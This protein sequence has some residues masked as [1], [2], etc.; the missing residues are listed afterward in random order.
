MNAHTFAILAF[1][2]VI[3]ST[4]SAGADDANAKPLRLGVAGLTH[5]HVHAVLN[6]AHDPDVELVGIAEANGELAD[7]F[8]KQHA[9]DRSLVYP[10]LNELLD[11]TQP[12]AV[13]AFGSIYEHLA[14]VEACAPR[15]IHVMVEKPLAVS[16]KHAERMA[17]LARKHGVL[18]LTNYET[19]WYGS[20]HELYDRVLN[21]GQVGTLRKL[22]VH[23]GHRGP[24]E[25]GCNA[26]FLE[27]LTDPVQNGGGAITDF[28]CYGANL[29][30][31]LMQN[32]RPRSVTAVTQQLKPDKYPHVDDEATILLTYPSAQ[33]V[34]QAS[35]NWP[36]SRKDL[37]AYG[38]DGYVKTIDGSEM[39]IRLSEQATEEA[40]TA[41]P[42][43][44]P[45]HDP[46]AYFRAAVRGELDASTG[47]SSL[48]NNLIVVEILDAARRSA[49]EG[50]VVEIGAAG[51]E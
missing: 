48:A 5:T 4:A 11:A 42:L 1:V 10:T 37:H 15:G 20:N 3:F 41:P 29:A 21:Q 26:E 27:W 31:W 13:A 45:R 24:I 25:I 8:L 34:I 17:T 43:I 23:D 16:G 36:F 33:M 46:F 40:V 38:A 6:R 35:W 47:L 32:K 18:L 12:E 44:E 9:L 49:R 19:T 51:G 14:V 7:R 28:G 2:A 39:R 50:V 30:T 22:V